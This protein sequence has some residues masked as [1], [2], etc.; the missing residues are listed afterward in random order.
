MHGSR[1]RFYCQGNDVINEAVENSVRLS[2][3]IDGLLL[4]TKRE[5][6]QNYPHRQILFSKKC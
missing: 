4:T 6:M 1:T 5:L 3:N 2:K